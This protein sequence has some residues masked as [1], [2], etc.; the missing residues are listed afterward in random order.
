VALYFL[1]VEHE[2]IHV[3]P[4]RADDIVELS[5]LFLHM[6]YP[7]LRHAVIGAFVGVEDEN[8]CQE[9]FIDLCKAEVVI[10]D[11]PTN[12]YVDL[13]IGRVHYNLK[14]ANNVVPRFTI[15][16]SRT[17]QDEWFPYLDLFVYCTKRAT[18]RLPKDERG[19]GIYY[20]IHQIDFVDRP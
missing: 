12:Y 2:Y 18:L 9:W 7:Y 15:A 3:D 4:D 8:C 20:A 11:V 19:P 5:E 1:S 13:P 17:N 6:A 14:H 16:I 10:R